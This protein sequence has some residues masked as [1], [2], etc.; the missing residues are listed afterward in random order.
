MVRAIRQAGSAPRDKPHRDRRVARGKQP[1]F[2]RAVVANNTRGWQ[3]RSPGA[4]AR[5]GPHARWP[6]AC[7]RTCKWL[8]PRTEARR[9]HAWVR[10]SG[11]SRQPTEDWQRFGKYAV[12]RG[13]AL[14][15]RSLVKKP[16]PVRQ[17]ATSAARRRRRRAVRTNQEQCDIARPSTKLAT[18][19]TLPPARRNDDSAGDHIYQQPICLPR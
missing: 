1:R 10:R 9:L 12:Y 15:V 2:R 8:Q 14:S 19:S 7:V 11:V 17:A 5:I 18:A 6:A 16:G 4:Q 3:Y 13:Y